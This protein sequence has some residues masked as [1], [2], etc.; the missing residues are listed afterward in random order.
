MI[1][2]RKVLMG[3]G[4]LAATSHAVRAQALQKVSLRFNWSWIGNFA[5][6]VLGVQRGY[7]RDLGIDLVLGQGKGSGATV[8]QAATRNDDFVWADTS[9]LVVSAAQGVLVREIMV[10]TA[11]SLGILW[12]DGRTKIQSARDLIGKKLSATPGDG[13][14]QIWPAVLAANGMQPGDVEMVYVDGSAAIAAL[15]SG[16]VDAAMGGVSDQP[17]TLRTAGL[18]AKSMTFAAMGVATLGSGLITHADTVKEQPDLCRKM[19][20]GVRR[21]WQAGLDEPDAAVQALLDIADTPLNKLVLRDSLGVFQ[22]LATGVRPVGRIDPAAMQATLDL[23]KHY[24]GV[25]TDEPASAFYTNAFA[26]DA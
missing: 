2:R 1:E 18:P 3:V 7:F 22:T 8:R 11:S 21:S 15:R 26:V 23:L 13:N 9:A 12:I 10:L 25:K 5:P 4:M 14:T 17:V 20:A 19:V 16:R 6:V 24:G